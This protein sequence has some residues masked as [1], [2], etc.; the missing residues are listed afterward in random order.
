MPFIFAWL[1]LLRPMAQYTFTFHIPT[2]TQRWLT[3][4]AYGTAFFGYFLWEEVAS[5]IDLKALLPFL[6]LSYLLTYRQEC[7]ETEWAAKSDRQIVQLI[8]D[9]IFG[10]DFDSAKKFQNQLDMVYTE[11]GPQTF[12]QVIEDCLLSGNPK[13]ANHLAP[14]VLPMRRRFDPNYHKV[15]SEWAGGYPRPMVEVSESLWDFS[16]AAKL[17]A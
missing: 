10:F 2:E 7:L 9:Q 14:S 16:D 5:Y 15:T 6:A 12:H 4:C 13:A 17:L 8:K 3:M 11:L 1:I